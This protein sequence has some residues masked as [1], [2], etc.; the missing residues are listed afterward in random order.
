MFI[1][2]ITVTAIKNAQMAGS[3]LL[4]IGGA[5]ATLLKNRGALQDIPQRPILEPVCKKTY[6]VT[7]VRD[8][9]PTVKAAIRKAKSG[10]PGPVFVEM[11]LDTLY[12]YSVTANE[13][14]GD[15]KGNSVA[16][17]VTKAFM[18]A[19]LHNLFTDG[20]RD[21]VSNILYVIPTL[22]DYYVIVRLLKRKL[23]NLLL[24]TIS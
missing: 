7:T 11:P 14:V 22:C 18:N 24:I 3:P 2:S 19:Y 9:V 12:P 8:I 23:K 20:F 5:A 17:K 1:S 10:V 13:V 15:I 6:S 16:D 21:H 4:I